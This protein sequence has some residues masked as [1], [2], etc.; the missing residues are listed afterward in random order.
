MPVLHLSF[1]LRIQGCHGGKAVNIHTMKIG[2]LVRG[3]FWNLFFFQIAISQHTITSIHPS[4]NHPSL[5]TCKPP[6]T[7]PSP[8]ELSTHPTFI[9]HFRWARPYIRS[10]ERAELARACSLPFRN[11]QFSGTDTLHLSHIQGLSGHHFIWWS[12]S[13]LLP[14]WNNWGD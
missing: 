2:E 1:Q 6:P 7:K 14:Q 13:A 10:T 11:W 3:L 12:R 8:I 9:K 4:F 5:C